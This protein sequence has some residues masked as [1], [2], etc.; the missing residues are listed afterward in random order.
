MLYSDDK[1][2]LVNFLKV[3][4]TVCIVFVVLTRL[5]EPRHAVLGYIW[6]RFI[7]MHPNF[8][9]VF[10]ELKFFVKEKKKEIQKKKSP[11]HAIGYQPVQNQ[12]VNQVIKRLEN[13]CWLNT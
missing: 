7:L 6:L 9:Y 5:F 13:M 4:R 12:Q 11:A 2:A 1:S 10:R 3:V 8:P